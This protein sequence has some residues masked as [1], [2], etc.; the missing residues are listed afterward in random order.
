MKDVMLAAQS[1]GKGLAE[2][3]IRRNELAYILTAQREA[4]HIAPADD[5]LVPQ[6]SRKTLPSFK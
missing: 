4:A 3:R 1:R 6:R 5:L 2:H